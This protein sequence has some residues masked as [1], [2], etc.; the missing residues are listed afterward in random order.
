MIIVCVCVC[1]DGFPIYMMCVSGRGVHAF[2]ECFF[3]IF[4]SEK[5]EKKIYQHQSWWFLSLQ[6][7]YRI[8]VCV[9]I[10]GTQLLV[11]S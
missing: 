6:N 8:N 5:R 3:I 2:V 10:T 1:V 11:I 4:F 9:F 7:A